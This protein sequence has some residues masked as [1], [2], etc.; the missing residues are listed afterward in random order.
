MNEDTKKIIHVNQH[1][2]R[3]NHK[4]GDREPVLTVKTHKRKK[5]GEGY[6]KTH[7]Q[8][9]YCHEVQIKGP[10]KIVYSPDNPLPCG[11]RVWVETEEGVQCVV[12]DEREQ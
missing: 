2:I 9:D 8:N 5:K 3:S 7:S 10:S 1:I 4:T 11:A 6:N 12:R